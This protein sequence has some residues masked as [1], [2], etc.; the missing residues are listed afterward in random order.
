MT[1]S[2]VTVMIKKMEKNC[3]MRTSQ[4]FAIKYYWKALVVTLNWLIIMVIIFGFASLAIGS[5]ISA[6]TMT[7]SACDQ[8]CSQDPAWFK[9]RCSDNSADCCCVTFATG[10][11]SIEKRC[12]RIK[13]GS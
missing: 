11:G 6:L 3:S 1:S 10:D 5:A 13:D 9:K 8:K 12:F 7:S 4:Y 2:E